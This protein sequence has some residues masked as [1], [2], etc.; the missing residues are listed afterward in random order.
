MRPGRRRGAGDPTWREHLVHGLA[1]QAG[2]A[3]RGDL[4]RRGLDGGGTDGHVRGVVRAGLVDGEQSGPAGSRYRRPSRRGRRRQPTSPTPRSSRER[5]ANSGARMPAIRISGVMLNGD[6]GARGAV[7]P[8]LFEKQSPFRPRYPLT[9]KLPNSDRNRA[10]ASSGEKSPNTANS[11]TCWLMLRCPCRANRK[12]AY[13]LQY[14]SP[15][16]ASE[17]G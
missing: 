6:T 1:G 10:R 13:R 3:L 17:R 4:E 9:I 15:S 14:R 7:F 5:R 12:P 8:I 11:S 16:P 2:T